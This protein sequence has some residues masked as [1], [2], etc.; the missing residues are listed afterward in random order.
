LMQEVGMLVS[1]GQDG[2]LFVMIGQKR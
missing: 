2:G 1:G